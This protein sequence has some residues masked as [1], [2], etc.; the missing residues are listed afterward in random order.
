[1]YSPKTLLKKNDNIRKYSIILHCA[2]S[3]SKKQKYCSIHWDEIDTHFMGQ[4]CRVFCDKYSTSFYLSDKSI[5]M[6]HRKSSS[7]KWFWLKQSYLK[8]EEKHFGAISNWYVCF[9]LFHTFF[10]TALLFVF[11]KRGKLRYFLWHNQ[12]VWSNL[13]L[14]QKPEIDVTLMEFIATLYLYFIQ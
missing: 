9:H 12:F 13:L 14:S 3:K 6:I 1:M 7:Q 11:E 8:R 4:Y 10:L 2:R 5:A